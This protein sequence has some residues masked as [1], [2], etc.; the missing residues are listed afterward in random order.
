MLPRK[1]E[2]SVKDEG[3]PGEVEK[4]NSLEGEGRMIHS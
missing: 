3:L 2:L 1:I 4:N